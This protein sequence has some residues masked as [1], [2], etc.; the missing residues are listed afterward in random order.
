MSRDLLSKALGGEVR[1]NE[2]EEFGWSKLNMCD[3]QQAKQWLPVDFDEF[4]AMQWHS[5]TFSL[6]PDATQILRG[7]HCAN[8]AFVLNEILAMQFHIEIDLDTIRHWAID[9]AEKHPAKTKSVQSGREVIEETE[10]KFAVSSK[11]AKHLYEC[12]LNF[13][14]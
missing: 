11:L 6:P 4:Y 13:L 1:K 3:N 7:E 14:D 10:Y 2:V 12:W 8:Q 5:D 9:L